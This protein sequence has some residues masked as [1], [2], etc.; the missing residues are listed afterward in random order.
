MTQWILRVGAADERL[1]RALALRRRPALTRFM[2]TF[3]HVGDA[4]VPVGFALLLLLG[5]IPG[6]TGVATQ[7]AASLALAFLLSQL[8]KRTISRPRPR[9][10]VGLASLV[11]PPDRFSFPSGHATA[12]LAVTLPVA[13]EVAGGGGL[14]ILA[15]LVVLPALLVGMSRCYL[16]VHYPGDV[17]AGWGIAIASTLAV[18]GFS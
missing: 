6:L 12:S 2:R 4:P 10:P 15:F 17:V 8:L 16:G 9:L 13:L 1:L 14:E 3:T 11:E 18:L 5:G 7:V